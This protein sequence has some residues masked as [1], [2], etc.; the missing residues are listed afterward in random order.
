MT[1]ENL[2]ILQNVKGSKFP[3]LKKKYMIIRFGK[4]GQNIKISH[5]RIVEM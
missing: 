4:L 2:H 5:M 1:W 3:E